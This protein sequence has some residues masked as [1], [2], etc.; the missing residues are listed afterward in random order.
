MYT[1]IAFTPQIFDEECNPDHE[2][3][4]EGLREFGREIAPRNAAE[5]IIISDL[6]GGSSL[7]VAAETIRAIRDHKAKDLAQRCISVMRQR[8]SVVR[9]VVGEWPQ[10]EPDWLDECKLSHA[11]LALGKVLISDSHSQDNL[12]SM[13]SWSIYDPAD[14]QSGFWNGI[15]IQSQVNMNLDDQVNLL[16]PI[17]VHADYIA[18]KSPQIRGGSDDETVFAARIIQSALNRPFGYPDIKMIEFHLDGKHNP[19]HDNSINNII[20]VVRQNVGRERNGLEIQFYFWPHYT[21][22]ELVAGIFKQGIKSLRW[23]ISMNHIARPRDATGIYDLEY[24]CP[25]EIDRCGS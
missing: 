15:Q 5:P 20:Q 6:Y 12:H 7:Q 21:D 11:Q 10:S 4:R 24:N 13:P 23:G 14:D 1:E 25:K 9:P 17:C 19:N 22:R 16:R 2:R 18:I 8:L 3:W